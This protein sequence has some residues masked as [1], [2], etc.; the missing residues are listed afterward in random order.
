MYNPAYATH[1]IFES[2]VRKMAN[3]QNAKNQQNNQPNN[4]QN[5]PRNNQEQCPQNKKQNQ[6][7]NRSNQNSGR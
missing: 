2:G 5:C 1:T 6:A 7:D 4:Q 3:K